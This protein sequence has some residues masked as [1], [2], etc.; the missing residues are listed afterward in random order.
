MPVLRPQAGPTRPESGQQD[1]PKTVAARGKDGAEHS[2]E[3]RPVRDEGQESL[4]G[5]RHGSERRG[6]QSEECRKTEFMVEASMIPTR[7]E[8][9][10][11]QLG[12]SFSETTGAGSVSVRSQLQDADA[13]YGRE[14]AIIRE[15]AG[16]AGR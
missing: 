15:K 2:V 10:C 9:V 12:R 13:R 14:I 3:E 4:R 8:P 5:G 7:S 11:F 6:D 1:P 16:A